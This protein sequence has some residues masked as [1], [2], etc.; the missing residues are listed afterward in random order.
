MRGTGA[1]KRMMTGRGLNLYLVAFQGGAGAS[2]AAQRRQMNTAIRE[3][4]QPPRSVLRS[5][6]SEVE[7]YLIAAHLAGAEP[8]HFVPA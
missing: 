1:R 5:A 8:G 4:L 3:R 2:D 7:S 6:M